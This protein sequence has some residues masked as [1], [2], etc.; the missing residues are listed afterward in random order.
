M[1]NLEPLWRFCFATAVDFDAKTDRV[2]VAASQRNRL[3]IYR[4][5]RDYVE[6]RA[7]L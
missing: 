2:I 3:Q 4:K 7:N 6:F 5:V 1:R